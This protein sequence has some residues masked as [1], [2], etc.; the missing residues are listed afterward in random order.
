MADKPRKFNFT[1]HAI[2]ALP[3]PSDGERVGYNDTKIPTLGV[4]VSYAGT[5][6]FFW[7]RKVRGR[8]TYRTIGDFPDLSIENAR[9]AA[10]EWNSKL[11]KWKASGYEGPSPFEKRRDLTLGSVLEDYIE[12]HVKS[13][14]K[15][16]DR[17][18]YGLRWGFK[19]YLNNW[20]N[21]K[22]STIDE[23]QVLKLYQDTKKVGLFTANRLIQMLRALFNW[24]E[25]HMH[26]KG[27]NPARIKL[28]S[29]KK[30]RRSRF[31]QQ[32]EIPR[33]FAA[34]KYRPEKKSRS[35]ERSHRD[36]QDFVILS[37]WTGARMTD[38]LSMQWKSLNFELL[39]WT[40]PD[41]KSKVPYVAPLVREAVACL[42]ERRKLVGDSQWIFP[43]EGKSGH[44]SGF[45][46]TWPALLKRAKIA[47]F[48]IH[49][50]RRTLG[51]YMAIGGAP[52]LVIGKALGHESL[53]A[54]PIY[55]QLQDA[56]VR[57]AVEG[58][59]RGI[60]AASVEKPVEK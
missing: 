22:L 34:L 17:S 35:K 6:T 59:V 28:T 12:R 3:I 14:A 9:D 39:N 60:L 52:L 21:R 55:A 30:Y 27:G 32:A 44:L 37:L 1:K 25:A 50:L 51:S 20:S 58:A 7:F 33:F 36:L 57:Q 19:K 53:G 4:L 46:H 38:V 23:T 24:A 29:E 5:R 42:Q 2:A 56:P 15:N 18:I 8:R 31:L 54:T 41:S 16:P 10:N 45:K 13:E 43:G 47:D 40:I 11:A 26:W 48:R 49:D